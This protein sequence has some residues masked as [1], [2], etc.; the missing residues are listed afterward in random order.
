MSLGSVKKR[1]QLSGLHKPRVYCRVIQETLKQGFFLGAHTAGGCCR[2]RMVIADQ[3]QDAMNQQACYFLA[4]C[5]A[6]PGGLARGSF[7][8]NH[9]ISQ[10]PGPAADTR[11]VAQG[12]SDHIGRPVA[13]EV[14][15][16]QPGYPSVIQ[17]QDA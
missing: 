14:L 4:G 17:K 2:Q 5:A 3:M 10:Q 9:H 11:G 7:D 1:K 16:I 6:V 13:A 15:L 8:R 12:K